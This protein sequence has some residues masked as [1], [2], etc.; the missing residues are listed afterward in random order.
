[1]SVSEAEDIR[2]VTWCLDGVEKMS[3]VRSQELRDEKVMLTDRTQWMD[4][5]NG[6]SDGMNG[7]GMTEKISYVKQ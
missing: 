6:T 2:S 5:A 1:M 4:I 3:D 7:K